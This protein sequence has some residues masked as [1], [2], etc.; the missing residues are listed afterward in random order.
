MGHRKSLGVHSNVGCIILDQGRV[1]EVLWD[2]GCYACSES[3]CIDGNCAI[4]QDDCQAGT[5]KCDFSAYISWYGTDKNGRYLLSAG[6]RL[7]QFQSTSAESYY[8]YVLNNL[9]TDVI[10]FDRE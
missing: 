9:D 7:S 6:Q 8:N 3:S 10:I 1:D 4:N 5:N 2:E